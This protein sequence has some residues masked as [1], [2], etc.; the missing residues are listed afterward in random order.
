[1]IINSTELLLKLLLFY[2]NFQT[3]QDELKNRANNLESVRRTAR[4][5][6]ETANEDDSEHIREQLSHLDGMWIEVVNLADDKQR[7]LEEALQEVKN[8]INK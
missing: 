3:F 2:S 4:E 7:R 6:L 1:M 5:L 8:K